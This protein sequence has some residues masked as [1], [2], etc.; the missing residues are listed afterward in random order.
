MHATPSEIAITQATHRVLASGAAE[1]PPEKLSVEYMKH[2]PV[3][4]M[5]HR[6]NIDVIFQTAASDHIRHSRDP[7]MARESRE[8]LSTR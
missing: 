3:T 2:M 4:N 8:L 7:N 1:Q 6:T 5:V